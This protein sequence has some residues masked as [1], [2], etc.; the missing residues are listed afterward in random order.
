MALELSGSQ[1]RQ[2]GKYAA[3]RAA[4]DRAPETLLGRKDARIG[5]GIETRAALTRRC[6]E[7]LP[8]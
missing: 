6:M 2:Q 8:G 5:T 4:V 1:R 7:R 3:I